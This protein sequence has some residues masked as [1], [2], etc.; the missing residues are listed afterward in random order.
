MSDTYQGQGHAPLVVTHHGH[1]GV[2]PLTHLHASMGHKDSSVQVDVDKGSG[3]GMTC[4]RDHMEGG[5]HGIRWDLTSIMDSP[6]E[7]VAVRSN[8]GTPGS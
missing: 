3:L 2:Q 1:L 7:G 8:M 6:G 4:I 5:S